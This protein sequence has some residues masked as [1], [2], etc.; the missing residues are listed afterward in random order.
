M[1]SS[2]GDGE[3]ASQL[4]KHYF[5]FFLLNF[6]PKIYGKKCIAKQDELPKNNSH[7]INNFAKLFFTHDIVH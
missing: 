6:N 1:Q 2:I 3:A 4:P 7:S 5:I